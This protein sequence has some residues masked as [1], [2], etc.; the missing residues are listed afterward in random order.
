[1]EGEREKREKHLAQGFT[2]LGNNL[3]P[4]RGFIRH[5]QDLW[6][7]SWAHQTPLLWDS[8]HVEQNLSD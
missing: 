2:A 4:A 5:S 7:C 8:K 6:R 3:I 1:M